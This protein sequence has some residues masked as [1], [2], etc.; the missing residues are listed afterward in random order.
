METCVELGHVPAMYDD[1]KIHHSCLLPGDLC[2]S[3]N[4]ILPAASPSLFVYAT[5]PMRSTVRFG[6]DGPDPSR[7]LSSTQEHCM[8]HTEDWVHEDAFCEQVHMS[9][10][11]P[12]LDAFPRNTL[13]RMI[14]IC[15]WDCCLV[16]PSHRDW[17][18]I[19]LTLDRSSNHVQTMDWRRLDLLE[20]LDASGQT[21]H[22]EFAPVSS[23]H[24]PY[25]GDS[26]LR[27]CDGAIVASRTLVS[28]DK[29][30][31]WIVD[32]PGSATDGRLLKCHSIPRRAV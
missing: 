28:S 24:R 26:D 3:F 17:C 19:A 5:T 10:F 27:T 32:G 25:Q 23:R 20:N 13:M 18:N 15:G 6:K 29:Y 11:C 7:E 31:G 30:L 8:K 4:L 14:P 22:Y 12:G 1:V 21:H 9:G 2:P 16:T